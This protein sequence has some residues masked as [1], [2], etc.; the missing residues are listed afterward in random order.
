MAELRTLARPYAGA[1]FELARGDGQLADWDEAL[2][3]LALIV[4]QPEVADLIGSP[5]VAAD[6]LASA[7][8][9]V[10][11]LESSAR[12]ANLVYL[13]AESDRLTLLPD[14]AAQ[15]AERRA[16]AEHRVA[17][18]VAAAD[19]IPEAQQSALRQALEQRLERTVD[20]TTE[21]EPELIGGAVIRA[22]DLVI[23]GSV[24]SRIAELRHRVAQ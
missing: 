14:I 23:D 22:G 8:I 13:L 3:N 5:R 11:G 6:E 19:A 16:A 18:T 17:V 24:R 10:A 20:V 4:R 7:M 15:F 1:A 9:Q 2:Q 12:A 21:I